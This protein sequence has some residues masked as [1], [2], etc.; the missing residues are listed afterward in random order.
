M[1]RPAAT[2]G[3]RHVALY[4][5]KFE[6]CQHFYI[7]LLGMNVEWRPDE[8]NVY[9]TSGVDNLALHRSDDKF[10]GKQHLDHI[11]FILNDPQHVQDWYEFLS[12]NEVEMR[13]RPKQHRDG[14][15]SFY[16]YDPDGNTVQFI[17]HPPLVGAGV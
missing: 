13:T 11:G 5:N 2:A 12:A 14:A 1:K 7:E 16:C 8:D 6:K 15:H 9:L 10:T 3:L 4:V 17:Y